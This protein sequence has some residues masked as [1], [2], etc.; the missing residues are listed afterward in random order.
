MMYHFSVLFLFSSGMSLQ[1]DLGHER[2]LSAVASQGYVHG[3]FVSR[4]KVFYSTDGEH[5]QAYK[6]YGT[7]MTK[8]KTNA[9]KVRH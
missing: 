7:N 3:M 2:E 1:I 4:Y 9:T 8:Y 5:W 6:K